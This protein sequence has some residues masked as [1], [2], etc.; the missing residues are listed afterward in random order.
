VLKGEVY[1]PPLILEDEAAP[2]PRNPA[3]VAGLTD[4]QVEVLAL[5]VRGH[6]NK[7]IARTMR[8]S[9]KTVK[10]HVTAIFK[11]FGVINRTQAA[12]MARS[13]GLA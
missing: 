8:I 7:Q 10:A 4:R 3:I 11:S 13:L 9:E 12:A 5:I 2:R 6:S 1:V